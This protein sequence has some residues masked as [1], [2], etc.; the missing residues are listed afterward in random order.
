MSGEIQPSR[1]EFVDLARLLAIT[2]IVVMHYSQPFHIA[3]NTINAAI[4]FA[5]SGIHVFI[6]LS[7]LML[8]AKG[9]E[10]LSVFAQKRLSK[11]II[12]YYLVVSLNYGLS[13]FIPVYSGSTLYAY[14]GHI[15]WYKALDDSIFYSLGFE[16]W[17]MSTI[18]QLYLLFPLLRSLSVRLGSTKVFAGALC[19]SMLW[20]VMLLIF[21]KE[22]GVQMH[23]W[24]PSFLWEFCLGFVA[25]DYLKK[26]VPFWNIRLRTLFAVF[27][28]SS[29]L[30][31][32]I[33]T[34]FPKMI[35]QEY[36]D[37]CFL[38]LFGTVLVLIYR[39]LKRLPVLLKTVSGFGR[40]SY[41]IYLLHGTVISVGI[42][43]LRKYGLDYN[44]M[45]SLMMIVTVFVFSFVFH[46]AYASTLKLLPGKKVILP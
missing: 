9:Q 45:F 22:M 17:F 16:F 38:F 14:L 46:Q 27:S 43:L 40:Y 2:A 28:L 23:Y 30:L 12:P 31:I 19:I 11:I 4:S 33:Y 24:A 6:F 1:N 10:S 36:N 37:F 7:G 15:F 39:A 3:S 44:L 13:L 35:V 26:G 25:A 42:L 34:T 8:Y 18:I 32:L 29:I 21:D 41:Y 20:K 5:G